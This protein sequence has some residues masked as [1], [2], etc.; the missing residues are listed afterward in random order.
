VRSFTKL[1]TASLKEFVRDRT[2]LSFTLIFP[3]LLVAFFGFVYNSSPSRLMLGVVFA[4]RKSSDALQAPAKSSILAKLHHDPQVGVEVGNRSHELSRLRAG[5][6]D[7]VLVIRPLTRSSGSH[8]TAA[9][10]LYGTDIHMGAQRLQ[11]VVNGRTTIATEGH[12][13]AAVSIQAYY[14]RNNGIATLATQ[15]VVEQLETGSSKLGTTTT[16]IPQHGVVNSRL[17]FIV[18]GLL[19]MAIMWLGIFAAIPLVQQR[20]QQVLRRF[21][22]TPLPLSRLV[23]AQVISRLLI[24]LLQAMFIL[25]V[26][27][28]FFGVPIVAGGHSLAVSLAL[29]AALVLLGALSFVTIGYAVAALST[30]QHAAHGWAQLLSMP[31]ILLCGV[32]FSISL[33]PSFLHPLAAIL[34]L[35]YL[36][37]ALRQTVVQGQHFTSLGLDLALL[38]SWTVV[39]LV[40]TVRYFRWS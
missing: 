19:A 40:V 27:R 7:A 9:V 13:T 34:P 25:A 3:L 1:L 14:D 22:V 31:M 10:L 18:P 5:S 38:A 20:E 37:D 39:A 6:I 35:T 32:F 15:A 4:E 16:L 33:L 8:S 26:A 30:T 24:S 12:A 29:L 2:S 36:A 21:A 17:D 28:L 11:G 23:A